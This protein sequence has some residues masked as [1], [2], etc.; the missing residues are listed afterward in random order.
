MGPFIP[1]KTFWMT[2]FTEHCTR[3]FFFIGESVYF[4]FI[5]FSTHDYP[6]L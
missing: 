1:K 3:N 2:F 6:R 5:D 4:N